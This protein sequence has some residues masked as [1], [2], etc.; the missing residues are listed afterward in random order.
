MALYTIFNGG[1]HTHYRSSSQISAEF[2]MF[3]LSL[4]SLQQHCS[5]ARVPIPSWSLC[6]VSS[7]RHP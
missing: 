5:L 1:E 6:I 4:R 2:D 3:T 7:K